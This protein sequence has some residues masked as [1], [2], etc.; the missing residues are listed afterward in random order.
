MTA[1]FTRAEAIEFDTIE[2]MDV[3]ASPIR[4]QLLDR[5][6]EP[7]TVKEVADR[8]GVPVTRLYHHVNQLVDHGFLTLV[9]ERPKGA[10]TERVFCAAAKT[11]RPSKQFLDTYGIEGLVEIGKLSFRTAEALFASALQDSPGLAEEDGRLAIGFARLH[12]TEAQLANLVEDV[13]E[14][15][16]RYA[17]QP[18][19]DVEVSLM[20]A[21]FP[22]EAS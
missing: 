8:M 13:N 1:T 9:E 6:R 3:I 21:V 4:L 2:A 7:A 12:L 17:E 20:S 5:F 19:G 14:L 15:I 22:M 10:M 11:F 16:T 18:D